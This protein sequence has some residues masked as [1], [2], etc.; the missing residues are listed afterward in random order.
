MRSRLVLTLVLCTACT[1]PAPAPDAA[2]SQDA[3]TSHDGASA[4][5]DAAVREDPPPDADGGS[6]ADPDAAAPRDAGPVPCD[7]TRVD[8]SSPPES[9]SWRFGGGVGYP[10]RPPSYGDC[11]TR[12][13]TRAE[14]EAALAAAGE[15][16]VVFIEGDARIDLTGASLCIPGGVTLASDRG[17]DGSAG[18]LLY[19]T[20]TESI[21]TL[22]ACGDDVRITGLRLYGHEPT[23]CPPEW[24]SPGH[25][26]C[27]G[28][29]AGDTNCRDC[30]PRSRGIR[31]SD[32]D[33]LEVDN[34]E[35]AGW[36]YGAIELVRS[37]DNHVHHNEIHHNQRQGLG[38]GVV[39]SGI[40]NEADVVIHHNRFDYNR[41]SVAGSGAIGQSYE[42]RDNLVL[43]HANGHVF[44]MHGISE[45]ASY[46]PAMHGPED[47]AGTNM[48]I[49]ANTVLPPNHYALVVRGRP[50]EGAWLYD[51][52]LARRTGEA[53]LQ[54][55]YTGRFYVDRSPTGSAPNRY[56]QSA[57]DCLPLR[58]CASAG[59]AGP[60]RYL[61]RSSYPLSAL[62]LADFDG[63]GRAD[64]FRADGTAWWWLSAGTGSWTQLNTSSATLGSLAFGDFDGDGADDVFRATGSEWLV[65]Y[66]GRER[67]T[68][69]RA[70]SV[71]LS[72]LALGDFDG[73][74]RTD[75]FT[76]TGSEWLVS[77]GGTGAPTRLN[78]S[79]YTLASLGFADVDGDG[80][81]D[82][83]R[84]GGGEWHV[85]YGGAGRWMTL[86][87]SNVPLSE[88]RFADVDGDGADDFL[89]FTGSRWNVSYG[90]RTGWQTLTFRSD[91]DVRFADLDGDGTDDAFRTGCL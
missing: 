6:S 27:T 12:V 59:G 52:C 55:F 34:C 45:S 16:D 40:A 88:L 65:S 32:A 8:T 19:V 13:R 26:A 35:L 72:S 30:M 5:R 41:H 91:T 57:S 2:T 64:V 76:T 3:A 1:G 81:I 84:T 86:N 58:F 87:R 15:G 56:G 9:A 53:A 77:Y 39:L 82:V 36:T 75:V 79:S 63:D 24:S 43:E 46:D 70:S 49:F 7:R 28:D 37:H 60:W 83:I 17:L 23:Q 62:A 21:A 90:G 80:R 29:I 85:S 4:P 44:D 50:T 10:D 18:A 74:G 69:L 14:L 42:A 38:Y 54:R 31:A 67:W 73:D 33:R 71:P 51:N 78:A 11:V 89:H 22:R 61:A 47:V 25:S 20:R 68:T 66:R 48:R